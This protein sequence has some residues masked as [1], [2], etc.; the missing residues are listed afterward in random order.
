MGIRFA[1]PN[2]HPLHVKADLAGKRGICP[3]CQAR[4]LIPVPQGTAAVETRQVTAQQPS[5]AS[6]SAATTPAHTPQSTEAPK[7]VPPAAESSTWYVRPAAGGQFGPAD[8]TL[9]IQWAAEGRIGVDAFVWRTGWDDWRRA[10]DVPEHFPQLAQQ[11]AAASPFA[12]PAGY[13]ASSGGLEAT[14]SDAT[15][16]SVATARYQ[17]RK[18]QSARWQMLAAVVLVLLAIGL[19]GLL[20]WVVSRTSNDPA[21]GVP[22]APANNSAEAE[23][24]AAG[25]TNQPEAANTQD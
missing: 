20:I 1:C 25:P 16:V 3:Q 22:T 24:D 7:S 4:F 17:R 9:V 21:S 10:S 13:N 6:Q 8:D 18:K 2:G 23:S 12:Q 11:A 15:D 14:S 19:G 5:A